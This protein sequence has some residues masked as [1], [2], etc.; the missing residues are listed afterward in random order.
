MKSLNKETVIFFYRLALAVLP[1]VFFALILLLGS[2][3]SYVSGAEASGTQNLGDLE[4]GDKV[5]DPSWQW[6]HRIDWDYS[7]TGETKPVIWIVVAKDHYGSGSGVTLLAEELIGLHAFDNSTDR[8]S[9]DGSNHWG[10]SGT[11]DAIRGLRPWLYSSGIHAD[12]GFYL[13]FSADFKA[14]IVP[15]TIPNKHWEE[16]DE[17]STQDRVFIPSTTELGD[18]EH[19]L[20]YQ[21]GMAYPYFSGASNADRIAQL[22]G[23]NWSYWT[24]SPDFI[25]SELLC[26]IGTGGE[27]C[28]DGEECIV[29]DG[30]ANDSSIGVR[31]ALNLKSETLVSKTPNTDG[32]YELLTTTPDPDPVKSVSLTADPEGS[33]QVGEDFT[34]TANVTEGNQDAEFR[35]YYKVAGGSWKSATSYSTDNT[36]TRSTNYVGELQVGVLARAVGSDA[37]EEARAVIDYQIVKAPPVEAVE[38]IADPPGSQLAGEP[39]S[40]TA[41]VTEGNQNAEFRFYYRLLGG[42]WRSATSYSTNSAWTVSTS[43]VGEVQIGVIAR[44]IGS[45]VSEQAR[46]Y[47][48]YE[49]TALE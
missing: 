19:S 47:I 36:W 9:L 15:V 2:G 13:A 22:R 16:G 33:Q 40:F 4:I 20:T 5:V 37:S 24:R 35:F 18:T 38:I 7:G 10:N 39:M 14:A 3:L 8:G 25:H 6:E 34:F 49:I 23:T 29:L 17:Y 46:D 48:D 42:K 1:V 31:P 45:G 30:F 41:E 32:A 12:E 28:F 44:A 21:I 27:L 11:T 26:S 43:Y